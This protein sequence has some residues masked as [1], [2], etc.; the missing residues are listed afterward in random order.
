VIIGKAGR[1]LKVV[2]ASDHIAGYGTPIGHE[3]PGVDR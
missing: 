3:L 2:D 1:N